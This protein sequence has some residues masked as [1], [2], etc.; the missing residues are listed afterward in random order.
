MSVT[1]EQVASNLAGPVDQVVRQ[2]RSWIMDGSLLPGVQLRQEELADQLNVSRLP[3]R[4]ALR[5]LTERELLEHRRHRG[6]FV[7]KRAKDSIQQLNRMLELLEPELIRTIRWPEAEEIAELVA[8]NQ[9]Q[10]ELVDAD[11]VAAFIDMNRLFHFTIFSLSPQTTIF[12]EV[13]RLWTL[14]DANTARGL[15]STQSRR[16]AVTE[17]AAIIRTLERRSQAA[18]L[19]TSEIHRTETYTTGRLPQGGTTDRRPP[20]T[21]PGQ[22][23]A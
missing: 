23:S 10:A 1:K 22:Q 15:A 3:V 5:I 9:Q 4:E 21:T 19:R 16:R 2:L 11:D 13:Q 20:R 14:I 8:M 12:G 18:L 7:A 17:H 6:Y